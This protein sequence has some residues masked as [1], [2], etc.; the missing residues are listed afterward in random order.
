VKDSAKR[1]IANVLYR[2]NS[3]G[4]PFIVTTP[5]SERKSLQWCGLRSADASRLPEIPERMTQLRSR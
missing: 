4:T 3:D 2:P 5:A 1:P